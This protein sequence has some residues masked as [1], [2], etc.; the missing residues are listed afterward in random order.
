MRSKIDTLESKIDEVK[1]NITK[2][3]SSLKRIESTIR[4]AASKINKVVK[5]INSLESLQVP[6]YSL[7]SKLK[8]IG[9]GVWGRRDQSKFFRERKLTGC[10][11]ACIKWRRHH[12]NSW[13]GV[14]L[15]DSPVSTPCQCVKN[16]RGHD[17][18]YGYRNC[19]RLKFI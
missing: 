2:V 8:F 1:S 4:R 3:E 13:N 14:F 9:R 17:A 19:F 7:M 5:D 15:S 11:K 6:V 18:S 16:D 10:I 12:G